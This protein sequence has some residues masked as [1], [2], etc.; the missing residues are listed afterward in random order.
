MQCMALVSLIDEERE[1]ERGVMQCI[2]DL[3]DVSQ[4]RWM[5]QRR[6]KDVDAKEI[7]RAYVKA[8]N[9]NHF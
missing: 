8:P 9:F 6:E 3:Y 7:G 2:Y 1:R 5:D 4:V